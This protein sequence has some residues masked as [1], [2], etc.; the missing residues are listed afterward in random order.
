VASL[1]LGKPIAAELDVASDGDGH[2][3]SPNTGL[4]ESVGFSSAYLAQHDQAAIAA[5]AADPRQQLERPRH[6]PRRQRQARLREPGRRAHPGLRADGGRRPRAVRAHPPRRPGGG[7]AQRSSG[8]SPSLAPILRPTYRIRTASGDY[9]YIEIVATNCV[10]D[11]AINGV[12]LNCRDVTTSEN[13]VRALKTFGQANQ[14][15]VHAVDEDALL[16][17]TCK[18]IVDVGGYAG[19][20]VGYVM[21]DEEQS[22]KVVAS[23]GSSEHLADLCRSPGPTTSEARAPSASRSAPAWSR[24]S[25]TSRRPVGPSPR[26]WPSPTTGSRAR[27]SCPSSSRAGSSASSCVYAVAPRTLRGGRAPSLRGARRRPQL[28]AQP[29]QGRQVARGERGAVPQP[30]DRV[31]DRHP[32]VDR[33]RLGDLRRTAR[34]ARSRAWTR[35]PSSGWGGS[36][37]CTPRIAQSCSPRSTMPR[38]PPSSTPD[39]GSSARTARCVTSACPRRRRHPRSTPTTSSRSRTSPTRCSRTRS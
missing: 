17:D 12:V 21:D 23:A 35:Q 31:A 20:W 1:D 13:L 19:A 2:D 25:R 29:H 11:P 15:L 30:R 6:R 16:V 27:A 8:T 26:A 18:T 32:R 28:R 3:A 14:V 5:P 7:G 24:S 4:K 36:R 10:D 33:G 39:S 34:S 37:A 38:P 9:R 22:V